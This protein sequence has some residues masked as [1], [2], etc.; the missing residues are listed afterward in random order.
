MSAIASTFRLETAALVPSRAVR[1]AGRLLLLSAVLPTTFTSAAWSQAYLEAAGG[2]GGSKFEQRCPQGEYL[3]GFEMRV[4]DDVDAIRPLCFA[5]VG[6][7]RRIEQNAFGEWHGGPNGDVHQLRCPGNKET[8]AILGMRVLSE[9]VTV[10]VNEIRIFCGPVSREPFELGEPTATY[11]G[12]NWRSSGSLGASFAGTNDQMQRCPDGQ[13]AVGIHGRTGVW[14]DAMGLICGT[15]PREAAF[16]EL[17]RRPPPVPL[18]RVHK[19]E[20]VPLGRVHSTTSPSATERAPIPMSVILAPPPI[21]TSAQSARDR[22]SPAAPALERQCQIAM[23]QA[24]AATRAAPPV[25]APVIPP[26]APPPNP[27]TSAP[28]PSPVCQAAR[29]ARYNNSPNAWVLEDQCRGERGAWEPPVGS[30]PAPRPSGNASPICEAA[31]QARLN[32]EPGAERLEALCR[33]GSVVWGQPGAY[34]TLSDAERH[35]ILAVHNHE[36]SPYSPLSW[37]AGLEQAAAR[38]A[39][40]L[41]SRGQL[42]H[43]SARGFEGENLFMSAPSGR[44]SVIAMMSSWVAERATFR[45]G[46]YPNVSVNG[47]SSEVSRYTQMIWPETTYVGCALQRAPSADFFVCRYSPPGNRSGQQVP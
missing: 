12:P 21:C 24:A 27:D 36:R 32:N 10:V 19:T 43:D 14:V 35:D 4:R 2:S 5:P 45:P 31:R 11:R 25:S 29:Q 23:E 18:G 13:V 26:P 20:P 47:S 28:L 34:T 16:D 41:G 44:Y 40:E 17:K 3:T 22:G 8:G 7:G 37:D 46:I 38:W 39:S 1:T 42:A 15:P 6:A 30:P 9:G 33:A